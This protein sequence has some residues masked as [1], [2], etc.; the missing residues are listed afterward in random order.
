[1]NGHQSEPKIFSLIEVNMQIAGSGDVDTSVEPKYSAKSHAKL[2][3][4]DTTKQND[5]CS[6]SCTSILGAGLTG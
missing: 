3:F 1:M 4:E 6:R 5:R 2:R